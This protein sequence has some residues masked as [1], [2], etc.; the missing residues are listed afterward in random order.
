M[1]RNRYLQIY[2]GNKLFQC[3]VNSVILINYNTIIHISM[4]SNYLSQQFKCSFTCKKFVEIQILVFNNR[5][6]I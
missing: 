3:Y 5:Y 6:A 4:I 1:K 2:K